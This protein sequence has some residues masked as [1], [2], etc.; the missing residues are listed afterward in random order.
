MFSKSGRRQFL[1]EVSHAA[2]A[3]KSLQSRPTLCD[4]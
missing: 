1:I 2:T 4:P 3:A